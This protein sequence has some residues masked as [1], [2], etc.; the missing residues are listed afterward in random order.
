MKYRVSYLPS[1]VECL[2]PL[3][4]TARDPN[5]R[6]KIE[7]MTDE[8]TSYHWPTANGYRMRI[9]AFVIAGVPIGL[10]ILPRGHGLEMWALFVLQFLIYPHLMEWQIRRSGDRVR[11]ELQARVADA[12]ACG[13]WVAGLGFPLWISVILFLANLL[14][15]T[16]SRG[17]IGILI[18][19]IAFASGALAS[20]AVIAFHVSTDTDGLVTLSAIIGLTIYLSLMGVEF[21]A[22][23]QQLHEVRTALDSQRSTLENANTALH[24]QIGKIHDLEE[25]LREQV[26]RDALT[27]LF[28]RRYLEGTL[29]RE[30]A[31][32]K[33]DGSP[34]TM[35]ILDLD[36]FKAVNAAHGHA[37]GDEV[38]RVF[39]RLLLDHARTEDIV[40][41]YGG[42]EFMLVS[43]R[44]PLAIA[45]SRATYLLN[46]FRESVTAVG[47]QQIKLTVSIGIA[48][49][50]DH[51]NSV[52]GLIRC[53]EHALYQAKRA[54]QNQVVVFRDLKG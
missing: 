46:A 6:S 11:A 33:R 9:A 21:F 39:A 50:P 29:E 42:E 31:R 52:G 49:V 27:G 53:V 14:N 10:H 44:M 47:D 32:C 45:E 48:V 8:T 13:A 15:H 41:R 38:L 12:V 22:H 40:C 35:M 17:K 7:I 3:G 34:L 2:P 26:N 37:A 54:G 36:R 51:A 30:M 24:D 19:P 18:G 16:M 1:D 43:P 28:N 5:R 4:S 23:T 20:T 25:K